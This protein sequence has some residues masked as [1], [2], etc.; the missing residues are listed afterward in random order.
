LPMPSASAS[1]TMVAV[2]PRERREAR[3]L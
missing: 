2:M 1:R 3:D